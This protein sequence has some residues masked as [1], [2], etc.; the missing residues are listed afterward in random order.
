MIEKCRH[1]ATTS[2]I[3]PRFNTV[4]SGTRAETALGMTQ[5]RAHVW[6]AWSVFVIHGEV[7]WHTP[8]ACT[9]PSLPVCLSGLPSCSTGSWESSGGIMSLCGIST[10]ESSQVGVPRSFERVMTPVPP[11]AHAGAFESVAFLVGVEPTGSGK[12]PQQ[13][14]SFIFARLAAVK[15]TFSQC[16]TNETPIHKERICCCVMITV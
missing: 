10:S 12:A 16:T 4:N 6:A 14:K 1:P 9:M 8:Q 3:R 15:T 13:I 7:A 5:P 11:P 2:M